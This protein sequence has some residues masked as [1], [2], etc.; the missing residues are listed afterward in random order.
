MVD[1]GPDF[2][3]GNEGW[4]E[5]PN[6]PASIRRPAVKIVAVSPTEAKTDAVTEPAVLLACP[7]GQDCSD[8]GF[9]SRIFDC[10]EGCGFRGCASCMEIHESEPHA[11]DSA[12]MQEMVRSA[13]HTW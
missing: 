5:L 8:G 10:R 9:V 4:T 13:G 7:Q 6:P 12:T 11:D 3:E 1:L 2:S